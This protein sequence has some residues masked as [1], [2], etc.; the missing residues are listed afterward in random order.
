MKKDVAVTVIVSRL[1]IAFLVHGL[2]RI[3]AGG[4]NI[5][6]HYVLVTYV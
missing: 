5:M 3:I 4:C 1:H 2:I 6:L